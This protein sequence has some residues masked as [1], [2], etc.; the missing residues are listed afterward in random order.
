LR[1]AIAADGFRY[2]V[3]EASTGISSYDISDFMAG[4]MELSSSRI[5]LLAA[6]LHQQLVA[7]E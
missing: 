2:D 4:D 5:D 6:A 1:R 3:L 7:V